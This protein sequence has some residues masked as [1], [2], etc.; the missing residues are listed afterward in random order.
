[1]ARLQEHQGKELLRKAGITVLPGRVA[2]SADEAVAAAEAI[3]YPVALKA[4]ISAGKRGLAGGIRFAND[5]DEAKV[6]AAALFN[7]TIHGHRVECLLVETKATIERELYVAVLSD[8]ARRAPVIM[9]STKGGMGIEEGGHD[10]RTLAVGTVD[11]L[12]GAPT[13]FCLDLIRDLDLP[14]AVAAVLAQV[15][16]RLYRVYRAYDCTL[17]EINPL[18]LTRD[19]LV[20]LDARIALDDDALFRHPELGIERSLE[21]GDRAPTPLELAAAKIDEHDHRGSAHF[22]QIDPDGSLARREGKIPIGFDGIGTGVSMAVMDELVPL[23]FLPMNF[24]DTSGNPTASKLYRITKIILAQPMIEGYVFASCLSSQQLDNTAR[25]IVKA[26]Q[27]IFPR[28]P[29]IP[30]VFSFRGAWDETAL[31]MFDEHGITKSKLVRLLG[32][33]ST[34]HDVA[35]ALSELHR[36]WRAGAGWPP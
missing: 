17:A 29:T 28:G 12:R 5:R 24:C 11:I 18:A 30:C 26:F 1:V 8:T 9:V 20:A 36:H 2:E 21:V 25:G 34:E 32:R 33:D 14:G 23:G 16:A 13:Y 7:A 10:K 35:V 19:G 15:M 31:A 22:V 3:G 4:Q 27:E 6:E